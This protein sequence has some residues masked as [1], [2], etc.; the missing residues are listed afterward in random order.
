MR[1]DWVWTKWLLKRKRFTGLFCKY[2][3]KA[4]K[5]F[6]ITFKKRDLWLLFCLWYL[7]K[8]CTCYRSQ[9]SL[10]FLPRITRQKTKKELNHV[11][12][13]QDETM[14]WSVYIRLSGFPLVQKSCRA[15]WIPSK[16]GEIPAGSC[17]LGAISCCS[18]D[19]NTRRPTCPTLDVC[20]HVYLC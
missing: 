3:Y 14:L 10:G 4:R 6:W 8:S 17:D 11:F 18:P 13:S 2:P 16:T 7:I 5:G 20:M 9:K 15:E 12:C 19:K 1:A